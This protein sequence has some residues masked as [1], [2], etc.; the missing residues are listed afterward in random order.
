MLGTRALRSSADKH[1]PTRTFSVYVGR[2][3]A[4]QLVSGPWTLDIECLS[5]ETFQLLFRGFQLLLE[6]TNH[7]LMQQR[8]ALQQQK[9][10]QINNKSNNNR[11]S[12]EAGEAGEGGPR[13]VNPV[14]ALFDAPVQGLGGSFLRTFRQQ[15]ARGLGLGRGLGVGIGRGLPPPGLTMT[16]PPAQFLGWTSAG[17][18]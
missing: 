8:I 11:T 18:V 10:N 12:E 7:T 2:H 1:I 13:E 14:T 3:W 17:I 16:P 15:T 6:K 4:M 5:D 9:N